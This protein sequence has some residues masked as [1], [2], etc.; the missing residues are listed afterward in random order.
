MSRLLSESTAWKLRPWFFQK[1]LELSSVKPE[2]ETFASHLNYQVPTYVSWNT[3]KNAYTND[4]FSMPWANLKFYTFSPF[5]LIVT[6]IW[7]IRREMTA[8]IMIFPWRVT[9]FWFP[10][11]VPL[12]QD[13]PVALPPNVWTLP[14]NKGFQHPL[15]PKINLLAVNLSG[16]PSDTQSFHQKLSW[17]CGNHQQGP[18]MNQWYVI[19]RNK[20]PHYPD[21]N[22]VLTFMHGMYLNGCLYSGLCAVRSGLSSVVTIRGYLKLSE[23]PLVSRYLKC[24]YNRHPPL[25][26]YVDIWEILFCLDIM[27]IWI[28][29]IT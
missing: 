17:N 25:P 27:M 12:L 6:F 14:S 3:D 22:T 23:H 19:S 1:T 16:G 29:I 13:F 21:I 26:K 10:M 5:S 2:I 28:L 8:G 15:Y 24:I 9:Q 4:A 7:K 18:D 20:Y 11:I